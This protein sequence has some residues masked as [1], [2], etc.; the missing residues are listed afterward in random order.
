MKVEVEVEADLEE[1]EV[2]VRVVVE[3][4]EAAGARGPGAAGR[5]QLFWRRAVSSRP[6]EAAAS[7]LVLSAAGARAVGC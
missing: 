1:V 3:V 5:V 2:E 7:L 6:C 4:A